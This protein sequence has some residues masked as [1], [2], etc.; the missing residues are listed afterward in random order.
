MFGV[1]FETSRFIHGNYNA[2]N[3]NGQ[4]LLFLN[5]IIFIWHF[6]LI[7]LSRIICFWDLNKQTSNWDKHSIR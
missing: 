1:K 6:K 2:R 3:L 4:E 7:K 5:I